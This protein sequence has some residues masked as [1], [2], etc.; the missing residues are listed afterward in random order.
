MNRN[1]LTEHKPASP[2]LLYSLIAIMVLLWSGNYIVAKV[3]L[4]E[5]PPVLLMSL[6]MAV[7]GTLMLP[8]LYNELRKS[9]IQPTR[10]DLLIWSVLGLGGVMLN[11]FTFVLGISRT[12]VTHS[13]M[14][15]AQARSGCYSRLP[16]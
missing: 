10:R 15:I 1:N 2:A 5:I 16:C 4:R 14:L 6:R 7:S 9:K 12:T 11:Q 8:F 3:A 13:S